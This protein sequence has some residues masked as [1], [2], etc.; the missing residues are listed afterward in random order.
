MTAT[1]PSTLAPLACGQSG[2]GFTTCVSSVTEIR[3]QA[4]QGENFPDTRDGRTFW[5]DIGDERCG[6]C[7]RLHVHDRD[8]DTLFTDPPVG[9]DCHAVPGATR[10]AYATNSPEHM[11]AIASEVGIAAVSPLRY[12]CKTRRL[13]IDCEALKEMIGRPCAT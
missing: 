2:V 12:D 1:C 11:L 8:G 6:C 3:L 4:G 13:W 7:M 9:G 10:V 5:V